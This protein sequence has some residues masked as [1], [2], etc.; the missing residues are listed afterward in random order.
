M[1]TFARRLI[2]PFI[3]AWERMLTENVNR[4]RMT[5]IASAFFTVVPPVIFHPIWVWI[6]PTVISA[7]IFCLGVVVWIRHRIIKRAAPRDP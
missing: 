2:G 3:R 5:L 7:F 6:P 1:A 4:F